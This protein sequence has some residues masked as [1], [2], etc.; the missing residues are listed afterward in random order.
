MYLTS[1]FT[2]IIV[3][4]L[5][6]TYNIRI[7][8]DTFCYYM[9]DC[10]NIHVNKERAKYTKQEHFINVHS[11]RKMTTNSELNTLYRPRSALA[12]ALYEKQRN[13][14]Q[15]R[16]FDKTEWYKVDKTRLTPEIQE[17]FVQL[18]PDEETKDFLTKCI[19]KS[20]WVWTQIWYLL[21]KTVLKYFW[22]ITDINGWL[23]RG[24]MF[25][26]SRAQAGSLIRAGGH[27]SLESV[28]DL[29][30]GDGEVG[31]R[32]AG[33]FSHRFATEISASMRKLLASK[34]YSILDAESWSVSRRFSCICML[35]LLDRCSKP[36]TMLNSAREALTDDGLL[37]V[38]LVLPYKPYV[39]VTSDHKP[40]ERLPISGPTFEDQVSSFIKFMDNEGWNIA[41][42]SRTP[43]FCEGDFTQS[44]YWLDDS[45][46]VFT[47][48]PNSVRK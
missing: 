40:E 46:Y 23:G 6:K 2:L 19:E 4:T 44:Y 42:W 13:D 41:A 29:G 48:H 30:A 35:N 20:S 18:E 43:Y 26:L 37:I 1:F 11:T 27:E 3:L 39:E 45:V 25:V 28:V 38:A 5:V 17:K 36:R 32:F 33:L 10:Q 14:G 24:S 16:D 34:G 8:S 9:K 12:R 7:I 47:P 31:R 15:L 22:T 21:A